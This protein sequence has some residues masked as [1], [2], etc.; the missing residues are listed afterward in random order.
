MDAPQ[1]TLITGASRGI[2]RYLTEQLLEKGHIVYGC[3]RSESD[4]SHEHYRHECVDVA[5]EAAVRGLISRIRKEEGRLDNLINNAG[6]ASMNHSLLTPKET[7]TKVLNTNLV[8]TFLFC[9]EAAKLMKKSGSGRV[10]N[11]TTVAV[12]LKLEGEAIYAASKS[13]VLTL[14]Q[15]LSFEFA[16]YGITV[17][18]IGPTPIDTDLIRS[19][20]ENKIEELVQRQAIKRKGTFQDVGNVVEFFLKPESDFITGQVLYLGGV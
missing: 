14:T 6:I 9:R 3:S 2:G 11:F 1:V 7:V 17:N 5:D 18:A 16:P 13:A 15:V 8:G 10:V 19:V 4:L 20:P 12:P